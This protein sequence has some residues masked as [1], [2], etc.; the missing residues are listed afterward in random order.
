MTDYLVGYRCICDPP[1]GESGVDGDR[2]MESAPE[3]RPMVDPDRV[4]VPTL[5]RPQ[6]DE[7]LSYA[8]ETFPDADITLLTV[9]TP[10]GA[11]LS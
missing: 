3:D 1:W 5:G 11:P 10:L 2:P 6:E 4:L 7:A 9:V 8:L